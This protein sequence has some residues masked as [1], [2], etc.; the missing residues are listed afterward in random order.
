MVV[1][2]HGVAVVVEKIVAVH[3]VDE[4]V[5]VVVDSIAGNFPGIG[6]DIGRQIAVGIVDARVDDPH[7]D[8]RATGRDFPSLGGIDVGVGRSAGLARIVHPIESPHLRIVRGGLQLLGD[9][10]LVAGHV[11]ILGQVVSH[12][13]DRGARA[14]QENLT[15]Q[16]QTAQDLERDVR[17]GQ[18]ADRIAGR[19]DPFERIGREVDDPVELVTFDVVRRKVLQRTVVAG[20]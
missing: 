4:P 7:D 14:A 18:Q 16:T 2:V 1:V 15:G 17:T 12:D 8:I 20:R 13:I 6:P 19:A 3:V 5:A 10:Q 9:V 11:G